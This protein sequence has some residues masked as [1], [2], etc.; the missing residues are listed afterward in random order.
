MKKEI[1]A[2]LFGILTAAALLVG[3]AAPVPPKEAKEPTATSQPAEPDCT[4]EGKTNLQ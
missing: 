3:C 4:D 1:L 2:V